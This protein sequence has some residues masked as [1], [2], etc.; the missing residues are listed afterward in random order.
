MHHT[1][2]RDERQR[3]RL[4]FFALCFRMCRIENRD[5][6]FSTSGGFQ[7]A[8]PGAGRYDLKSGYHAPWKQA[9]LYGFWRLSDNV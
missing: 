1:H 8:H 5:V 6:Y 2:S 9:S 7:G 3:L 4:C